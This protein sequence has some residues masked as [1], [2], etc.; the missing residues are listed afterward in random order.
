MMRSG[1]I[2]M[3][4]EGRADVIGRWAV[5]YKR[6]GKVKDDSKVW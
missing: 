4:F 1:Q 3:Y 2:M 5:R 6:H